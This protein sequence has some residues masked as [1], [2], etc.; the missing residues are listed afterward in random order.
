[1]HTTDIHALTKDLSPLLQSWG[2]AI[3]AN[4]PEW[5]YK[6]AAQNPKVQAQVAQFVK[7]LSEVSTFLSPEQQ[8]QK[9]AKIIQT[10]VPDNHIC[11]KN[12]QGKYLNKAPLVHSDTPIDAPFDIHKI[13]FISK[14]N[15]WLIGSCQ[16]GKTGVVKITSFG[17]DVEKQA[18]LRKKFIESFF[19]FKE[20]WQNIIFDFRGNTG[21]DCE[22]IREIAER[23]SGKKLTYAEST[24]IVDTQASD[25]RYGK[26]K[27]LET[28]KHYTPQSP[29]DA[30]TGKIFV[31]QDRLNAS[32]TEGAIYMLSQLPRCI[33][34]GEKTSGT[35]AGG[36]TV[37]MPMPHG[38]LTIGTVFRK[39]TKNGKEIKEKEGIPPDIACPPKQALHNAISLIT[40]K[41]QIRQKRQAER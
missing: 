40:H 27:S 23:M 19:T 30:Y 12:R 36:A 28:E 39:R 6:D 33:T 5:N 8:L 32:A 1:M 17:G 24:E 25:L 15:P 11:I 22:V 35:F 4:L 13:M 14:G 16:K 29:N 21:G 34:I 41:T 2:Q 31:L 3:I 37:D 26:H 20:N 18:E 10:Y 7:A 9:L 38:V